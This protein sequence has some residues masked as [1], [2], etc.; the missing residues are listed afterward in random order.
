MEGKGGGRRT[1]SPTEM[2]PTE[3]R[4]ALFGGMKARMP[5]TIRMPTNR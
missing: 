5:A 1:L 4:Y 3:K 2:Q